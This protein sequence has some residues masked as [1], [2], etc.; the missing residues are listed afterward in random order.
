MLQIRIVLLL[1]LFL[2]SLGSPVF[3]KEKI[4]SKQEIKNLATKATVL[5]KLKKY[6]KSL[7]QSRTALK[8]AIAIKD[9]NLIATCYNTIAANFD[10]MSEFEKAYFY[11]K[12]GILYANRTNNSE[13]KKWLNNNLGNVYFFDKK[14]YKK[15]IYY[16]KES[17][18]YSAKTADS[19][20]I[21]FTKLNIAWAYF[22]IGNFNE[23]LPYLRFINKYHTKFGDQ[24]T[25]V[26][27][28]M[29]N[30]MYYG[31]NNEPQKAISF[32]KKAIKLGNQGDEKFDLSLTHQEYSA[33][34]LK[35]KDY[36]KAYENLALYN[37]ITADLN[38]TEKSNKINVAGINLELDEYKREID[39][40]ETKYKSKQQLFLEK[41]SRNKKISIVIISILLLIIILFYF[42]F[43]NTRLKQKNNLNDIQSKIQLKIINASINGQEIERKKIASFLHDNISAL[44]SAAGLHLKVFST[45]SQYDSE[46]I[47][48]TKS[49]LN[50][51]H[52]KIRDLS[53]ELLP[54]LLARFGLFHA[55][56]DLCDKNSNSSIHF[57]YMSTITA[58]TRYREDFEMKMYFIITE[59]LNNIIKHSQASNAILKL[60]EKEGELFIEVEDKGKG[61]DSTNYNTIKGFGLSQVQARIS[62][63]NGEFTIESN[64]ETGTIVH[65][66]TPILY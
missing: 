2:N 58:K 30:G 42:F 11:Y 61:F 45:K 18:K 25:I 54:S 52:N 39:N 10:E 47:M 50:E 65:I 44:L 29:L 26:A 63:M 66:K 32:F 23:G 46:E 9:D 14:E 28:N 34:L 40:I 49:I 17:L 51:V 19:A 35:T 41:Q 59:L 62:H 24:S 64:L 21:V 56:Q 12:K 36:K 6:E 1:L 38:D 8:Y 3:S 48:K 16:Y 37:K 31:H 60:K 33:F 22:D 13:L 57:Q 27:L 4:P 15:G 5:L 20:Q 43:Q 55:L 53:H 7:I